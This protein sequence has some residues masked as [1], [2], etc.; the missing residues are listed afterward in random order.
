MD[1]KGLTRTKKQKNHTKKTQEKNT[2]KSIK[3]KYE[4]IKTKIAEK[5]DEDVWMQR[6]DNK[7][8]GRQQI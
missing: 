6:V 3:T 7:N 8:H 5:N 4:I 1:M 2:K